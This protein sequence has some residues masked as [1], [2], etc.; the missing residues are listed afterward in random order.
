VL[1]D[2]KGYVRIA[3]FGLSGVLWDG[4][5]HRACGT[6]GYVAPEVLQ[7]QP[8]STSVDWWSVGVMAYTMLVGAVS[9]F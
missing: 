8:Y 2:D 3:D 7:H 6:P 4:V 5:A 1:I 9:T